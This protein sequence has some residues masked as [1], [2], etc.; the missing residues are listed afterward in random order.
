MFDHRAITLDFYLNKN[1]FIRGP[2][3]SNMILKDPDID[4]VVFTA[5]LECYIT[6]LNIERTP[7]FAT[8]KENILLDIGNVWVKLREAGP[9]PNYFLAEDLADGYRTNREHRLQELNLILRRY[10]LES[11]QHFPLLVED[12]IFMETLLNCIK[13]EVSIYQ[14]FIS[15]TKG[16]KKLKLLNKITAMKKDDNR[17]QTALFNAESEFDAEVRLAVEKSP[18]FDHINKEKLSPLFLKLSKSSNMGNRFSDI[19]DNNGA[20]FDRE[21]DRHEFIVTYFEIIYKKP[22]TFQDNLAGCIENFLGP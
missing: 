16:A 4:V 21:S 7:L 14:H 3:I 6:H 5:T 15:K 10:D 18:L 13:H 2:M 9:D 17:D 22:V 12:N 11:I 8:G 20:V 1:N 19:L